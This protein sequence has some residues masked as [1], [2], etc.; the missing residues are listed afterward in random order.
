MYHKKLTQIW[1]QFNLHVF[2]CCL[3]KVMQNDKKLIETCA[4]LNAMYNELDMMHS[5]DYFR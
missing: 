5:C 3:I 2:I 4:K 1:V